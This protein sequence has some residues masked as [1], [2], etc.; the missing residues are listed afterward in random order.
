MKMAA[1]EARAAP[2]A[3]APGLKR[4]GP[5][6]R[7]KVRLCAWMA[8]GVRHDWAQGQFELGEGTNPVMG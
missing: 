2:R 5:A 4:F 1:C 8:E 6:R 7:A 3:D